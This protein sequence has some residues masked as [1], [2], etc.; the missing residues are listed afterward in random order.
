MNVSVSDSD[1]QI[2]SHG[3]QYKVMTAFAA[4]SKYNYVK[5]PLTFV[6]QLELIS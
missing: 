3:I 4:S 5:D 2:T 1:L 6:F